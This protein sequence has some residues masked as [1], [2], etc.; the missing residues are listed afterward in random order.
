MREHTAKSGLIKR[1][2]NYVHT[3][4]E[5]AEMI[6]TAAEIRSQWT[7]VEEMRRRGLRCN[8]KGERVDY[9]PRKFSLRRAVE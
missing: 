5:Q 9:M 3:P 4:A 2:D 8:D 1:P 6:A 7:H